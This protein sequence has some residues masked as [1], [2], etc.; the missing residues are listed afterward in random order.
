MERMKSEDVSSHRPFSQTWLDSCLQETLLPNT[1]WQKVQEKIGERFAR[2]IE[3]QLNHSDRR[4]M[5]FELLGEQFVDKFFPKYPN[6]PTL[7]EPPAVDPARKDVLK[8]EAQ[9]WLQQQL[10]KAA[11]DVGCQ[12]APGQ[13]YQADTAPEMVEFVEHTYQ[14]FYTGMDRQL[15]IEDQVRQEE[16]EEPAWKKDK[17]PGR[18]N[19]QQHGDVKRQDRHSTAR[20]QGGKPPQSWGPASDSLGRHVV[21]ILRRDPRRLQEVCSRLLGKQLP[22]TLRMY[23]WTDVLMKEERRKVKDHSVNVEKMIRERFGRGIVQGVQTLK[24]KSATR[25]PISGL[26]ENA[27]IEALKLKSATRSPIS[28]LVENAVIEALK[29]KSA[30]RSPISGLVENAVIEALKLKSA[31]RS[32][33][34]GLVENAV[35]EMYDRTPGMQAY[36]QPEQ[37]KEAAR[38][39]NILYTYDR[40][41]EPYL[42]HWLFPLQLVYREG[43][44]QGGYEPYLIHWL[45]PLQLVY[46]EGSNQVLN[47]LYTYDRSYEP[48]LIHWLFPLQLVYREGS[49]QVLNILYTYDRS[50]EP[51]LIHWLFPLQLLNILYTYDRSYEPYLIHWLFPLQLVYREGSNQVL[52]ILYTYDRSYE[53]YL[54]HW[55]FPL[56]L[57]YREGSNQGVFLN[58]LYTN[59]RSY[60]PYL[61]HWLFPLQLVYREGSNQV[62]NI[63]YTYDRSYE[64]YLIHWLFPLQLV[65]REG[66]NQV[67]NILYTYDRSYEP[68]LIHWLFPLQLVYREGSNQVLNILYTY[69]RSY[70]PYLIHWLFPLQLVYREGSNQELNILY[71]YDRSYEPYL[72]HWLFPL[73]LVYR[74]GSNQ[75]LNIL[76]TYDR[77]YEP[78]LIHWLFPLQLVYREG[79][80]QVLNIL[81]TYDRSYEPY[82]IHWLFPLQLVYREG[83]NQGV[84]FLNIL[85]TYD[86]SYEP[87]LIHWLFPL[88]LVYRE[89]SNQ[90]LNILY[91]YDRS[92]E[93]YLIHWLFPLQLVYREGSNQ[94]LNI[95]YTYDRSYEPYLIHWLFPLQ[96]VYREG[97]NQVLNILY[98]YDRSYEPYLIHWL[99]PLQ[100]VYR[101]GSNQG[102]FLNILYTYDRSYEPY[103]IHWLFPLQ[104]VYREGS[105]QVLNIL[106]TYDRS[107]EPYLIHWLF[108]LQ[109]VYREGSN[110]GVFY[111]PYL[112]HWLFPLQLVYREGSNQEE[113]PYELAMYLKLLIDSRFPKWP[114]VFAIAERVMDRLKQE[115]RALHR[116]LV[117]CSLKNVSFDPKDFLVQL[118]HKEKE[119]AQAGGKAGQKPVQPSRELLA[120]PLIFVRKWVGEGFVSVLDAQAVL[121]VWDQASWRGGF[122]SVLDAQAVLLVWDQAFMTD[123]KHK[124]LE[125]FCL[126]ILLLLRDLLMQATDYHTMKGVLLLE[127]CRLYT[128]DVQR[129]WVRV[130]L[131]EPC[132]LY[133]ADV[134]RGWMHLQQGG[135]PADLPTLNRRRPGTAVPVRSPLRIRPEPSP[136]PRVD[137]EPAELGPVGLRNFK[138]K[139]ILL[140]Q[141]PGDGA[142]EGEEE[143]VAHFDHKNVR[144]TASV[145]FGDIKLRSKSTVTEPRLKDKKQNLQSNLGEYVDTYS[146]EFKEDLVFTN[147]DPS[148]FHGVD[149]GPDNQPYAIVRASYRGKGEDD[150]A[151]IPVNL[152]WVKIPVYRQELSQ[153]A[154]GEGGLPMRGAR[155][156]WDVIEGEQTITV[157][158]GNVPETDVGKV[159]RSFTDKDVVREGSM[160]Y[161][162]VF[163][164]SVDLKGGDSDAEEERMP[165]TPPVP[166]PV[167]PLLE[168]MI[169]V[170]RQPLLRLRN[171]DND[172]TRDSTVTLTDLCDNDDAWLQTSDM[173][174]R[175]DNRTETVQVQGVGRVTPRFYRTEDKLSLPRY[176]EHDFT[177]KLDLVTDDSDTNLAQQRIEKSEDKI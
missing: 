100:L 33:I 132:R 147:L 149:F 6:N 154:S 87:Y 152:G 142:S 3:K 17:P 28:G 24:L 57:V 13:D 136:S 41:Y 171:P 80:N 38:V 124:V 173:T 16:E 82:L 174:T 50:Y 12:R 102:V 51:Y 97:S 160:M 163:D 167:L 127:P 25:S 66:S 172:V 70:E 22:G 46:R 122:V 145:Y 76:Y 1:P 138:V 153:D 29:L 21:A 135:L 119:Q 94:V 120:N 53:P 110:Q 19:N 101:E 71:T 60:E 96:L 43:S 9:A 44:N 86:R 123:W 75:V 139:L 165:S 156:H 31:T 55:L 103:L 61:I 30:T 15:V 36:S 88:Q 113:H 62:L 131:L 48:Y 118:I 151:T 83:S 166:S 117:E 162:T 164:P 89:G 105:N 116:H 42:I 18:P 115:D 143:W 52:N 23:V 92:Y 63:L 137:L 148:Q 91:T 133:T 37:L 146:I 78:Y 111:E 177:D 77:S 121:L 27:V 34:S 169:G 128:A 56:Q 144:L 8:K 4:Q 112:I 106:Y 14:V 10:Y 108:P 93:P 59:D 39:L 98:T 176:D 125:D 40:S 47:I 11:R 73:Q 54:I 64:P 155:P 141:R 170:L 85:Y 161:A 45:F 150:K 68:Y 65:Y 140:R 69:D 58:I 32:P 90:V 7:I 107:Y 114:E 129:G 72:I 134:Q 35:I 26:V 126:V 67:L 157:V 49:N 95:L 130:L 158:P 20:L 79:S 81:Y 159:P 104:L 175:P 2:R 84:L 168:R 99:F 74:E 109:L 5:I